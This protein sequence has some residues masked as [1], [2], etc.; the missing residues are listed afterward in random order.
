MKEHSSKFLKAV[1]YL[2]LGFPV[3]YLVYAAVLFNL[4][5]ERCFHMLFTWSYWFLAAW[6]IVAGYGLKEMRRWSWNVFL[7]TSLFVGYANALI[8]V[9]YS[10]SNNKLLAFV[11]SIALL[12]G[13]IFRL[14]SEIRVP[15]F[16]PRI[17]WWES[18]PRYKLIVPV[19]V[20]R[21]E[22]GFDGE[23]LDLSLGGVFIKTRTD[24]NQN[25]RIRLQFTL[26]GEAVAIEGMIVWRSQS[27]VTHP[28]GV[29]V[30]FDEPDKLQKKV[31]K[32]ACG[33]LKRISQMQSSRTRMSAEEFHQKLEALKSHKLGITAPKQEQAS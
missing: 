3:T 16:L 4:T 26:F 6:G 8:V 14:G 30:K 2:Y 33:H 12:V 13:L 21:A 29:G 25:E 20:E 10:Q 7:L 17:R 27:T 5:A 11:M 23:I 9:R 1:S 28:K 22:N 15:Y 31:L 19:K 24:V 18:N 32:A